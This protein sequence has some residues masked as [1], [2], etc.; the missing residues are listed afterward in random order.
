MPAKPGLHITKLLNTKLLN[1]DLPRHTPPMPLS[2]LLSCLPRFPLAFRRPSF[3][4]GAPSASFPLPQSF[5]ISPPSLI[6]L[7]LSLLLIKRR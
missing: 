4:F 1:I 2:D 5:S 6:L 7:L 3:V